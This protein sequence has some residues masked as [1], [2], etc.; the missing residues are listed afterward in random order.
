MKRLLLVLVVALFP[1]NAFAGWVSLPPM[2]SPTEGAVAWVA[3]D[4]AY[5]AGGGTRGEVSAAVWRFTVDG[6]WESVGELPVP[7][8]EAGGA[9]VGTKLYLAGGFDGESYGDALQIFDVGSRGWTTGANLPETRFGHGLTAL[10]GKL[11]LTGGGNS[12]GQAQASVWVY[13][14]AG[15]SWSTAPAMATARKHHAAAAQGGKLY[16]FGGVNNDGDAP[17]YLDSAEVYDPAS[18]TCSALAAMPSSGWGGVAT[19]LPD[20]LWVCAGL[21]DGGVAS[22]C[23]VYD[24]DGDAWTDGLAMPFAAYRVASAAA[25]AIVA[26]GEEV[27]ERGYEVI[28][29]VA[30]WREASADDDDDDDDDNDVDDDDDND[31]DDDDDD[32]NDDDASPDDDEPAADDGDDDK[33]GCGC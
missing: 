8:R 27:G 6:G 7:V 16:V 3:G 33:N 32:D 17:A 11:Y 1:I 30:V 24:A 12:A 28:A 29:R 2:P 18:Q 10:D 22:T 14:T 15:D 4:A 9:F 20:G 19:S 13:D 31:V 21:Q 26:G 25:G 23:H 5:V